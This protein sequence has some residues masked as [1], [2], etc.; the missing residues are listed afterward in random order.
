MK[1]VKLKAKNGA[2]FRP[3][4]C[5][6]ISQVFKFFNQIHYPFSETKGVPPKLSPRTREAA[7][8]PAHFQGFP[9]PP[10]STPT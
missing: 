1:A 10:Q 3:V 6:S 9:S 2:M 4:G 5:V 8:P 7:M